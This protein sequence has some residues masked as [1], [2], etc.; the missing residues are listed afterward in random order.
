MAIQYIED[1]WDDLKEHITDKNTFYKQFDVHP[2]IIKESDDEK[3]RLVYELNKLSKKE[4]L[5]KYKGEKNF[6]HKGIY[7]ETIVSAIL[8]EEYNI[9]MTSEA[10][11]K[12]ASR[13]AKS[14][15]V[16]KIPKDIRDI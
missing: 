6:N 2:S 8:D 5:K 13:F 4:L 15:Q 1:N 10:V 3:N 16:Q 7:K 11:K 9:K 14:I 12:S